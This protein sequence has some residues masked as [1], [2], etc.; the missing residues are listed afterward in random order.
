MITGHCFK[1]SLYQKVTNIVPNLNPKQ[2]PYIIVLTTD[3]SQ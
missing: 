3:S 2:L 1:E